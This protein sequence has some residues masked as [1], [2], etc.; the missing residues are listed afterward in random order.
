LVDFVRRANAANCGLVLDLRG[1]TFFGSAG[2]SALR[3][4]Q[5]ARNPSAHLTVLP[6]RVV[7]R[8]LRLDSPAPPVSIA[9][10]I[11]TAIASV[12]GERPDLRIV[13]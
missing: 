1:V 8:I 7:T 4:I 6:S 13:G 9:D 12:M 11:D 10:D 5:Q 3:K 2:L